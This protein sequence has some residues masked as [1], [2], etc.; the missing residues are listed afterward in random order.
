[1]RD[2]YAEVAVSATAMQAR[3]NEIATECPAA[4]TYAPR[5]SGFKELTEATEMSVVYADVAP[6]RSATLRLANAISD[7]RWSNR[8]LTR[9]VHSLATAERASATLALPDICADISAWRASAYAIL[10]TNVT[11][12]IARVY[13]IEAG[14]GSSEES[15]GTVIARLLKPYESSVERQ[16]VKRTE[17]LEERVDGRL[18]K[19]ITVSRRKLAAALGVS[20]L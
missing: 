8:R 18:T 14:A 5:D 9:L 20:A 16:T 4:L 19:V 6:V 7:L 12:F 1:M 11:E 15:L 13:K 10:P 3:T 2:A 17:R